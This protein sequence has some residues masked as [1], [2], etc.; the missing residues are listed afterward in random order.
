MIKKRSR[1]RQGK[2]ETLTFVVPSE[3]VV[4]LE[5]VL[6]RENDNGRRIVMS[7]L[8][9]ESVDLAIDFYKK[10]H[11]GSKP[12]PETPAE[13]K[14][15]LKPLVGKTEQRIKCD[16][17]YQ[18]VDNVKRQCRLSENGYCTKAV[19]PLSCPKM[20]KEEVEQLRGKARGEHKGEAESEE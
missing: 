3:T 2:Q 8:L 18:G 17:K 12:Q 16:G 5:A 11:E 1:A 6:D 14:E 7:D 10:K 4:K 20:T 9:R 13:P 19:K 15:E